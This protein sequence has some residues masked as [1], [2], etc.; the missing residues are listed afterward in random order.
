MNDYKGITVL[1]TS[2]ENL[3]YHPFMR[4]EVH[5]VLTAVSKKIIA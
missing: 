3:Y 5:C 2:L 1:L 4:E